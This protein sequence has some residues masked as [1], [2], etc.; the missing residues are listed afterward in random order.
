ML[1]SVV[2]QADALNEHLPVLNR[3][4]PKANDGVGHESLMGHSVGQGRCRSGDGRGSRINRGGRGS[5]QSLEDTQ[6][7]HDGKGP[8][9]AG[10]DRRHR[11]VDPKEHA[12]PLEIEAGIALGDGGASESVG[13]RVPRRGVPQLGQLSIV[14]RRHVLADLT[15]RLVDNVEVV[16]QPFGRVGVSGTVGLIAAK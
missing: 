16:Q 5:G 8:Q 2:H 4:C 10:G 11:L 9:L 3:K 13:A 6:P 7:E 1:E 14:A 12:H 15:D